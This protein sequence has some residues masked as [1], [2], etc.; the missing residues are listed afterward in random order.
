MELSPFYLFIYF[1]DKC[2]IQ[3]KEKNNRQYIYIYQKTSNSQILNRTTFCFFEILKKK[4]TLIHLID[5]LDAFSRGEDCESYV[6]RITFA[7][8]Q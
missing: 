6:Q 5:F 8:I 7:Q 4:K 2:K 3:E 1:G